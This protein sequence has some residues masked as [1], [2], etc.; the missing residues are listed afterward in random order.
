MPLNVTAQSGGVNL[1]SA[2]TQLVLYAV[3]DVIARHTLGGRSLPDG[4]DTLHVQLISSVDGTKSCALQPQSSP[5]AAGELIDT[6][7]AAAILHCST[8]WIRRIRENLDARNIGGRW[9]FPRQT[10]AEYAERKA[11]HHR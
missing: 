1:T 2:Q 6:T 7:E 10:V 9:L 5:S 4:F 11:G 3:R 8:S